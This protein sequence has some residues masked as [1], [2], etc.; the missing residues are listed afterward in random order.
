[1]KRF[2]AEKHYKLSYNGIVNRGSIFYLY[3]SSLYPPWQESQQLAV[4]FENC[5]FYNSLACQRTCDQ[6]SLKWDK[7]VSG[8]SHF[9]FCLEVFL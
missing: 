9:L 1:M 3:V 7:P 5:L 4:D 2:L 6:K 8:L